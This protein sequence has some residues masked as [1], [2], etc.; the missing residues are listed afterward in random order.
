VAN[1]CRET[2]AKLEFKRLEQEKEFL[3]GL[4][5]CSLLFNSNL[6]VQKSAI[7]NKSCLIVINLMA[8]RSRFDQRRLQ[9]SKG[10]LDIDCVIE[11]QKTLRFRRDDSAAS[12]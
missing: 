6:T 8:F 5:K 1:N 10:N 12:T 11:S 2:R 9:Q 3:P 7:M 4:L